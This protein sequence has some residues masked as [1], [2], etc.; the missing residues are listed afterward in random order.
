MSLLF[1]LN[2]NQTNCQFASH[3][4]YVNISIDCL[5]Q[6]LIYQFGWYEIHDKDV[7]IVDLKCKDGCKLDSKQNS[8]L[9]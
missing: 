4:I 9:F 5:K 7:N 6:I 1:V 2:T 3:I 8:N